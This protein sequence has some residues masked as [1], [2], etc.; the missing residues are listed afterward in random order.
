MGKKESK[1][2]RLGGGD[3]GHVNR[4]FRK[5]DSFPLVYF[6]NYRCT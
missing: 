4:G 2:K 6:L 1:N 5:V 3:G